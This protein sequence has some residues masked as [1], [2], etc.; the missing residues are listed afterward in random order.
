[1]T[2]EE[3][4]TYVLDYLGGRLSCKEFVELLTDYLDGSMGLWTRVRFQLHLGLCLG[5]RRHLQHL[6]QTIDTLSRLPSEPPPPAIQ[7]EL[8]RRFR[9]WKQ[10][11]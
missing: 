6:K 1:M 9:T 2:R 10:E 8:L 3:I 7:E 11:R 4:R 5:C